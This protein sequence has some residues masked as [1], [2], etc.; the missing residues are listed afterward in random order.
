MADKSSKSDV[1]AIEPFE[2]NRAVAHL[3]FR[4][5]S[6]HLEVQMSP[7]GLIAVG[8]LVSATLLSVV[9][10]VAAATRHLRR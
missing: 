10:I 6:V 2:P 4:R 8:F 5:S 3:E 1:K 7:A 9:P